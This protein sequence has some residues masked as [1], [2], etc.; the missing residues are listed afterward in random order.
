M[1][2]NWDVFSCETQEDETQEKYYSIQEISDA[3]GISKDLIKAHCKNGAL[4]A[5]AVHTCRTNPNNLKYV[6]PESTLLVKYGNP[7]QELKYNPASQPDYYT[8]LWAEQDEERQRQLEIP[9]E[10]EP[11]NIQAITPPPEAENKPA[12]SIP[13]WDVED[14]EDDAD[15]FSTDVQDNSKDIKA[16]P[17]YYNGIK[18]RSR[19]EARWAIFFDELGLTWEYEPEGFELEN[20]CKYLPDFLIKDLHGRF[21]GDLY[22]EVK[23]NIANCDWNKLE[24]FVYGDY[25]KD[26][27]IFGGYKIK[28]PLLVLTD[29]F[30]RTNSLEEK[31]Y[32]L[33]VC[34]AADHNKKVC[35]FLFVDGKDNWNCILG[36]NPKGQGELFTGDGEYSFFNSDLYRTQDAFEKA[37][38]AQFDRDGKL[39]N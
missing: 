23:G 2:N 7:K 11:Q 3:Y 6:I 5:I 16:L 10:P 34:E 12:N 1:A 4:K 20:N 8:N 31:F 25:E 14:D 29:I 36:V 27:S 32:V 39:L 33:R 13:R 37:R 24:G 22:I 15:D 17:A 30:H 18:F 19:L 26:G 28:R 21:T 38:D 35:T 9:K